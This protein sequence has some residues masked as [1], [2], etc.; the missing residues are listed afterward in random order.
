VALALSG[1][2]A[3]WGRAVDAQ[4]H[5]LMGDE[6]DADLRP[7][8]SALFVVA[9][10]NVVRI[11]RAVSTLSKD[12]QLDAAIAAV[13]AAVPGARN[14]RAR[15]STSTTTRHI[16]EGCG[17]PAGAAPVTALCLSAPTTASLCTWAS[18][19]F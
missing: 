11:A 16:G 7:A 8:D 9:V 10:R 14:V 12:R 17:C 5:R 1:P 18:L 3:Q 19:P 2:L 13:D 4:R 15:S 6:F